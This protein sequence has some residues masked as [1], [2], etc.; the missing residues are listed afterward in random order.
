MIILIIFRFKASAVSPTQ[1][2]RQIE[3]SVDA[4]NLKES[5]YLREAGIQIRLNYFKFIF[6]NFTL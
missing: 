5:E 6:Q 4:L 3:S 2:K 1:L